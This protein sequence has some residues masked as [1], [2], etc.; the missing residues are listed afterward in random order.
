MTGFCYVP[1]EEIN[2][3]DS[4]GESQNIC[5]VSVNGHSL[6]ALLDTGSSLSLLKPSFVT[7]V[8][9]TNTTKVQCVHGD[10]S[11]PELR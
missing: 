8:D 5:D 11:T 4:R 6:K 1:R 7:N 2:G 3:K 9:Y 10:V